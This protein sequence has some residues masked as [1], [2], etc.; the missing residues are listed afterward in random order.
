M[1][2]KRTCIY[3][4]RENKGGQS[5][6]NMQMRGGERGRCGCG[7]RERVHRD[8]EGRRGDVQVEGRRM[9]RNMCILR[10]RGDI[11]DTKGEKRGDVVWKSRRGA[12]HVYIL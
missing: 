11:K 6:D 4:V 8:T 12:C 7:V 10:G 1:E 3:N 9:A 2:G 5:S